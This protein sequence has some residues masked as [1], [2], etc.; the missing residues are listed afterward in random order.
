MYTPEQAESDR[1]FLVG[2]NYGRTQDIYLVEYLNAVYIKA[3]FFN[4][5]EEIAE[6]A[7]AAGVPN[8]QDYKAIRIPHSRKDGTVVTLDKGVPSMYRNQR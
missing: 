5:P 6:W 2:A 4:S 1:S 7:K 8:P 3:G